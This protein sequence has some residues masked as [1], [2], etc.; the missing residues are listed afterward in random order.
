MIQRN[1]LLLLV[2]VVCRVH[3]AHPHYLLNYSFPLVKSH[4]SHSGISPCTF[5]FFLVFAELAISPVSATS[6]NQPCCQPVSETHPHSNS[7]T[8]PAEHRAFPQNLQLLLL[9]HFQ[10]LWILPYFCISLRQ[11][12]KTTCAKYT[13]KMYLKIHSNF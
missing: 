7:R 1:G 8:G 3:G 10:C 12:V 2:T 13:F 4:H 6:L 9:S 11:V 5:K